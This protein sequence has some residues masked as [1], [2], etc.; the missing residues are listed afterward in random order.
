MQEGQSVKYDFVTYTTLIDGFCE[1]KQTSVALELMR[2]MHEIV[3]RDVVTYTTLVDGLCK[4]E[5]LMLLQ[6]G[7]CKREK[8]SNLMLSLVIS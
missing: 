2:E 3:K 4:A 5:H 1:T 6:S 8:L 7:R